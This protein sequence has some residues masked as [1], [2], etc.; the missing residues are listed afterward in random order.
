MGQTFMQRILAGAMRTNCYFI[1]DEDT[2]ET[3]IVDPADEAEKLG[4]LLEEK[5]LKPQAILLTHGHFDHIGAVDAL[6]EKYHAEVYCLAE[7]KEI[8]ENTEYNLSGLFAAGFTVKPD[9]LLSDGQE[10]TLAGFPIR[11]IATPGHT[12]GSC[13]YYFTE[14]QFLISGDTLFEESV[15]R[16]DFPTGSAS[17]LVRSIQEKLY[18]L[19]DDTPVYSGHGE[20][21]T[22][23]H[24]KRCNPFARAV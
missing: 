12:K 14:D 15:G 10:L 17:A 9:H 23:E 8:L 19:P 13:C 7:E 3:L 20:M 1:Y 11:V 6:R 5:G 18:L 21:T 4:R 2:K 16:S 24:E 22:I